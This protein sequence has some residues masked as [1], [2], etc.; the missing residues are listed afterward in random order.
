MTVF[1]LLVEREMLRRGCRL[2][3]AE[4]VQRAIVDRSAKEAEALWLRIQGQ[5]YDEI[6]E[7]M[8][9]HKATAW[10]IINGPVKHTIYSLIERSAY[11]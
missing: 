1:P 5:S 11:A 3:V 4:M 8:G 6:A 10:R 7:T 9:I 2:T